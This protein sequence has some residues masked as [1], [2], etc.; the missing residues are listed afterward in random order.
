M[1]LAMIAIALMLV[2]QG[3][4]NRPNNEV[5]PQRLDIPLPAGQ[6]PG[7]PITVK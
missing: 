4:W 3:Y 5:I 1:F 7:R 6:D 2:C